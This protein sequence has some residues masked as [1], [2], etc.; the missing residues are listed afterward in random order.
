[1]KI[2]L[3]NVNFRSEGPENLM[4]YMTPLHLLA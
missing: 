4:G 2:G 1:M 3:V